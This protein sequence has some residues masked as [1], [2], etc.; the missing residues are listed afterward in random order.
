MAHV[1]LPITATVYKD[2]TALGAA[3]A[4][5]SVNKMRPRGSAPD[6]RVMASFGGWQKAITSQVNGKA[7]GVFSYRDGSNIT[8]HAIG[9][10]VQLYGWQDVI[11]QDITPFTSYVNTL[12]NAM[13]TTANSPSILFTW[14]GHSL[15]VGDR[16]QVRAAVSAGGI[17]ISGGTNFTVVSAGT[18][19]FTV[20]ASVSAS[21]TTS[22]VGGALQ[23]GIFLA[24]GREFSVAGPGWGVGLWGRGTWGGSDTS[25]FEAR[26]HTFSRY[27]VRN[28]LACPSRQSLFEWQAIFTTPSELVTGSWTTGAGW[29]SGGA[30]SL[31]A[32]GGTAS[33]ATQAVTLVE[34]AFHR[35]E[36]DCTVSAGSFL[37]KIGT[38]SASSVVSSSGHYTFEFFKTVGSLTFSKDSSYV[39]TIT[40]IS[41]KQMER[42]APVPNCPSANNVMIVTDQNIV[43]VG[44]TIDI[45]TGLYNP[46]LL[47][48]SDQL[49]NPEITVPANQVWTAASNNEAGD[50]QLQKGGRIVAM[51]QSRGEVLI[52]TDAALYRA[53][54]VPDPRVVYSVTL[55]AEGC[56][57][58]SS[59]SFATLNGV[60][61]WVSPAGTMFA[62]AGG[63]PTEVPMTVRKDWFDNIAFVQQ[64]LVHVS[65]VAAEN[66]VEVHYPDKRDGT[67]EC[68]RYVGLTGLGECY[69]G[70]F[71]RTSRLDAGIT[72]YPW[73]IDADGYV[74]WHEIQQS[75][76]NST[77]GEEFDTGLIAIGKGD[78]LAQVDR[79][80]PDFAN[81]VGGFQ[82]TVK[83][84]IWPSDTNPTTFGP[85]NITPSTPKV[86]IG[87]IV[88]RFLSF[89]G[90]GVSYPSNIRFGTPLVNLT[91][92]GMT[93]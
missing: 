51:K 80:I 81:F 62:Y 53:V 84:Y 52:W 26:T 78:T 63:A 11:L 70:T 75:G 54:Y 73:A 87:F 57:A 40:N 21:S 65:S 14:V 92:T 58:L 20:Q 25:N 67:N 1:N 69:N 13:S 55:I 60:E 15:T 88:G 33:D 41:V 83:S 90:R 66:A 71:V 91:D 86:D 2:T 42:L 16:F 22:G 49:G 31:T 30:Q 12:S 82:L 45:A 38:V 59:R 76:D 85:F 24:T 79:F 36:F 23:L 56:G 5:T 47:R 19:N 8:T 9:T 43:M 32:S 17:Y 93:V 61:Y 72:Q 29:T 68:S 89:H 10:H 50:F 48:W 77:I 44:G 3:G 27:G 6:R 64:A 4:F 18:N 35:L 39:G 28:L 34:G 74:Y 7:R 46:M 37:A